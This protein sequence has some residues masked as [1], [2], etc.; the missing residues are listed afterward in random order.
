MCGTWLWEPWQVENNSEKKTSCSE[1]AKG[2]E[3]KKK[4]YK[5]RDMAEVNVNE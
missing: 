3:K 5:E 1:T 2:I 4:K